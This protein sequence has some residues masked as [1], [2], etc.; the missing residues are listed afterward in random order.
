MFSSVLSYATSPTVTQM[1]SGAV[2][3]AKIVLD[4][5]NEDTANSGANSKLALY[6]LVQQIFNLNAFAQSFFPLVT[7]STSLPAAC[8]I[9]VVV[10]L[11]SVNIVSLAL[12]EKQ[13]DYL[14]NL[15]RRQYSIHLP[16]LGPTQEKIL[17]FIGEHTG[18]MVQVA[19]TAIA[20]GKWKWGQK[21]EA[22]S[23]LA[24]L[25]TAYLDK[26]GFLPIRISIV[27]KNTLPLLFEVGGILVGSRFAKLSATLSLIM[28]VAPPILL[29]VSVVLD[30]Y[31]AKYM[32]SKGIVYP[33][34]TEVEPGKGRA[35]STT[36]ILSKKEIDQINETT[37]L[38][39][40]PSH[41]QQQ[42]KIDIDV[43]GVK[44]ETLQEIWNEIDWMDKDNDGFK[45][46]ESR[47]LDEDKWKK[48]SWTPEQESI[49]NIS[50]EERKKIIINWAKEKLDLFVAH[51][52]YDPM[53][54]IGKRPHG[55]LANYDKTQ[56][57][58]K[59][60]IKYMQLIREQ[61][62]KASGKNKK[63]LEYQLK[64][65]LLTFALQGGDHC[66]FGISEA[67]RNNFIHTLSKAKDPSVQPKNWR[68]ILDL[69]LAEKRAGIFL[70][71]VASLMPGA[72]L[73]D[74]HAANSLKR[75]LGYGLGLDMEDAL[76]DSLVSIS[77]S[78][79]I[80]AKVFWIHGRYG[81]WQNAYNEEKIKV[82]F[83]KLSNVRKPKGATEL[84]KSV[85]NNCKTNFI[86]MGAIARE[87]LDK[88]YDDN[89]IISEFEALLGEGSI[90][91]SQ[92]NDWWSSYLKKAD[93]EE[94]TEAV[95]DFKT[96]A[97]IQ[98]R[99]GLITFPRKWLKVM[100]IEMGYLKK[101]HQITK[102]FFNM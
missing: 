81:F 100:L 49:L 48:E 16:I 51:I 29:K 95:I 28:R 53:K 31:F 5:Y 17:N 62:K 10:S 12:K 93:C 23:A 74:L 65:M 43:T 86:M 24:I 57:K 19:S 98:D 58:A 75:Q 37:R 21:N 76:N 36:P 32:K 68:M 94:L 2:L 18:D 33:T 30:Y 97:V 38:L 71:A 101:E 11:V 84:F 27:F 47:V 14:A 52:S 20:L 73:N 78:A 50:G 102:T 35:E 83:E 42:V 6:S 63:E 7:K 88:A 4:K 85:V 34:L 90:S 41:A 22:I 26:K 79:E 9:A 64:H 69:K 77:A 13:Y 80:V 40:N 72:K 15:L 54:N 96:G 56:L 67:S 46:L 3:P 39:V 1:L 91:T 66:V 87:M 82:D 70:Y 89:A 61:I 92:V 59:I 60:S 55:D 25:G 99:K 45:L 8:G 44:Y